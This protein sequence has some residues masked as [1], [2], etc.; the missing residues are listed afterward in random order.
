MCKTNRMGNGNLSGQAAQDLDDRAG[1]AGRCAD[2]D[3]LVRRRVRLRR[4][5]RSGHAG[6]RAVA[7]AAV[8]GNA[9]GRHA[10][11]PADA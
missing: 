2:R 4:E 9:A 10:V 6:A 7:A 8:L 1:A 3:A 5:R 11:A